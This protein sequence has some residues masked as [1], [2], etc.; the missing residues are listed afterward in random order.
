M[1]VMVRIGGGDIKGDL[2]DDVGE[3]KRLYLRCEPDAVD[4]LCM[5]SNILGQHPLPR[6]L[7]IL[8]IER[9]ANVNFL[10]PNKGIYTPLMKQAT[11]RDGQVA[12]LAEFG[13]DVNKDVQGVYP[14]HEAACSSNLQGIR[15]LVERGADVNCYQFDNENSLTPLEYGLC[16]GNFGYHMDM[17]ALLSVCELFIELGAV[18]RKK[19]QALLLKQIKEFLAYLRN[20]DVEAPEQIEAMRQ[21]CKLFDVPIPKIPVFHDG[22]SP[23]V[24]TETVF[25]KQYAKLWEHLVPTFDSAPTLQGEVIRLTGRIEDEIMRNGSRNWN[26]RH[27]KMLQD[28]PEYM[29]MGNSL[30][31]KEIEDIQR[32]CKILSQSRKDEDLPVQL[33]KYAVKWVLQNPDVIPFESEDE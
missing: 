25:E 4:Y 6:E 8:A 7:A 13:A 16:F 21:L 33:Q 1:F 11:H 27:K 24:I 10:N 9:G 12:L 2:I 18:I 20:P 22:K 5:G 3:L 19:A 31:D 17:T 23:I 32:I 28:I 14:L 15:V 26:K 30:E 29:T